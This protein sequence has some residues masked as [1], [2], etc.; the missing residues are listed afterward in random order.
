MEKFCVSPL[1][2]AYILRMRTHMEWMVL[3]HMRRV[4]AMAERRSF[5]SFAALLVKVM[6]R[7]FSG[8]TPISPTRWAMRAVKTRVLPL[9]APASTRTAP[10][11]VSTGSRCSSFKSKTFMEDIISYPPRFDKRLDAAHTPPPPNASAAKR[12]RPHPPLALGRQADPLPPSP[13]AQPCGFAC[14]LRSNCSSR[15]KRSNAFKYFSESS[16]V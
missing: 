10:S 7:I 13:A 14:F 6:A 9:P 2:S 3:T 5:I 16:K 8:G 12:E 1:R 11:V 4:S 15:L